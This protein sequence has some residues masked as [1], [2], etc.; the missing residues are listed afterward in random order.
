VVP[1]GYHEVLFSSDVSDGLVQGMI[2]WIKQR[3]AGGA[4]VASAAKM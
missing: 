1:G 2:E 3:A 4:G